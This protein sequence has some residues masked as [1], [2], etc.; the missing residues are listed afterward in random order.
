MSHVAACTS[1]LG[2][3]SKAFPLQ[4][5]HDF[6]VFLNEATHLSSALWAKPKGLSSTCTSSRVAQ[7]APFVTACREV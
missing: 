2:I 7:K 5:A 6:E 3:L 4:A 1:V